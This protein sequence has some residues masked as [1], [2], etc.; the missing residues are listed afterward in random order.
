M[1]VLP[2][3]ES[4]NVTVQGWI[5]K[6]PEWCANELYKALRTLQRTA[7]DRD[8]Y[9]GLANELKGK[10][11][12]LDVVLHANDNM[13]KVLEQNGAPVHQLL[14]EYIVNDCEHCDARPVDEDDE[15]LEC[16]ATCDEG[17]C[18]TKIIKE[19]VS[20]WYYKI[21]DSAGELEGIK[22]NFSSG[23]YDLVRATD[24]KTG[25]VVYEY[26]SD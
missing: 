14:L 13:H 7:D 22:S 12:A 1:V 6:G 2:R 25:S 10:A 5:D 18:Q 15:G 21:D 16:F 8:Y 24:I 26:G 20:F 11:H 3:G 17:E 4:K 19:T 9:R 23:F